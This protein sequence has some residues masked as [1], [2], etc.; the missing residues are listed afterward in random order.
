MND[1]VNITLNCES[2][3]R[4]YD[5]LSLP[6]FENIREGQT[7]YGAQYVSATYRNLRVKA[8]PEIRQVSISGSLPKFSN[9]KIDSTGQRP[10]KYSA[11]CSLSQIVKFGDYLGTVFNVSTES[12]KIRKLEFS[13]TIET[14]EDAL[15]YIQSL[16]AHNTKPFYA[17]PPPRGFNT[18]LEYYCSRSQYTSK[19]YDYGRLNGISTSIGYFLRTESVLK[20]MQKVRQL[21]GRDQIR[22]TDLCNRDFQRTLADFHFNNLIQLDKEP[23]LN[24]D[25]MKP[26]KRQLFMAGQNPK[27]WEIEKS[28]NKHTAKKLRTEYRYMVKDAYSKGGYDL[29]TD[30]ERRLRDQFEYSIEN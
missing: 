9:Y 24:L 23:I 15:I 21:T 27:F 12:M 30:L 14:P 13:L 5:A 18:P 19:W 10:V 11:N 29:F 8:I 17:L 1:S 6:A 2:T 4:I 22:F 28:I 7:R 20:N 16:K 25:Y 3:N 26:Q